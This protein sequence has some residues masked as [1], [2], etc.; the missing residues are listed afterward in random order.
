MILEDHLGRHA[1]AKLPYDQLYGN[2]GAADDRL[3]GHNVRVCLD[4]FARHGV[5]YFEL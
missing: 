5:L 4:S 1:Y 3:A 2:A